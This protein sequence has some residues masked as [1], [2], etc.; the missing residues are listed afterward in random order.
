[1]AAT[2]SDQEEVTKSLKM[3]DFIGMLWVNKAEDYRK[4]ENDRQ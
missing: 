1:M 3:N 2:L 4:A